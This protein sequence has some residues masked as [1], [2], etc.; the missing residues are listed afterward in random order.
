LKNLNLELKPGTVLAL[1]GESGGGKST[2]SSLIQRYYDI[3]DGEILIDGVPLK[4]LDYVWFRNQIAAV[5]QEP[6]LFGYTIEENIAFGKNGDVSEQEIIEAAKQ[7][8]AH[9]FIMEFPEG[10][11][12]IVGERGVRLSGGQ[13]QRIAI[14]RALLK[15]PKILL[16]DEFSSA[17]D[18]QSEFLVQQALNR[19][20]NGRTALIIAHRLSTVKNSNVVCVVEKGEVVEK[21]SHDELVKEDGIYAKF[22][23]RQLLLGSQEPIE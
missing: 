17:L 19:L 21:G 13:K 22:V 18:A 1:V 5:N 14:A 9:D 12:T 11:K 16:L 10:Y 15:N 6:S 23:Q 7:S 4:E 20:M 2:V 3:D 8:N